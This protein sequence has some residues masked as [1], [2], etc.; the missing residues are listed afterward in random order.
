MHYHVTDLGTLPGYSDSVASGIND[1]GWVVGSAY[2]PGDYESSHAFV[3][4]DGS[5]TALNAPDCISSFASAINNHNQIV[6]S[7]SKQKTEHDAVLWQNEEMLSLGTLGGDQAYA[8]AINDQGQVV[9]SSADHKGHSNDHAYLWQDGK[10]QML[11]VNGSDSYAFGI[12]NKGHSVGCVN[13]ANRFYTAFLCQQEHGEELTPP[14]YASWTAHAINDSGDI[15]GS[16]ETDPEDW[17]PSHACLWHNGKAEDLGTLPDYKFCS[18]TAINNNGEIV[19]TAQEGENQRALL[20]QQKRL[21]DLNDLLPADAGWTLERATAINSKGQIV[22]AGLH[23]GHRRA[24]L[25]TP[26]NR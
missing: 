24:F 3:W 18:A 21:I 19:G 7:A 26:A 20:W 1:Q 2:T 6:G 23:N 11:P 5:M 25:L 22:G 8:Y 13:W 9:G 17:T 15:V 12:N 16:F 4:H 14:I 10:M